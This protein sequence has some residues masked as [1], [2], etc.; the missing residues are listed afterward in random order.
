MFNRKKHPKDD[1][2][3]L[4]NL[5]I[6]TGC[7]TSAQI[8]EALQL[9]CEQKDLRLGEALIQLGYMTQR[10]IEVARA[11]QNVEREKGNG[12]VHDL[13]DLAMKRSREAI[14]SFDSALAVAQ[15]I[16]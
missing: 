5:L 6:A 8:Q 4:G 12:A 3:S 9:Q 11:R 15:K 1:P 10:Q 16:K 13:A 7:C 14:S 2:S